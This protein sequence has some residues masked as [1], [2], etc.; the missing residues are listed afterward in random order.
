[1][2]GTRS[3]GKK[4]GVYD[5]VSTILRETYFNMIRN[6]EHDKKHSQTGQYFI[7]DLLK[8]SR[9]STTFLKLC[10][11]IILNKSLDSRGLMFPNSSK[12]LWYYKPPKTVVRL[13]SRSPSM[14]ITSVLG[15]LESG[16][17][18]P[19]SWASIGWGVPIDKERLRE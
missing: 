19:V 1:M 9:H 10:D 14:V 18:L 12:Q 7:F 4:E 5:T 6:I 13:R 3:V 2:L 17:Q 16:P 11:C 15:E 8:R